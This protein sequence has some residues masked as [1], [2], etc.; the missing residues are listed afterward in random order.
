MKPSS[1]RA[2]DRSRIGAIWLAI[3]LLGACGEGTGPDHSPTLAFIVEPS[4]TEGTA[5]ITPPPQV[6]IQDASSNTD[7]TAET[8]VTV[9]LSGNAGGATLAG[10][11][12]VNAVRGV[13]TF[14]GLR[15]DRPGTVTLTAASGTSTVASGE[16]DI[17]LTI[18]AVAAGANH[19]CA[20]TTVQAA[21]CWGNN[22]DGQLGDGTTTRSATAVLVQSPGATFA[23]LSPA[24]QH[25]CALATDGAAYCWGRGALLGD[26]TSAASS[27]PVRVATPPTGY[28]TLSTNGFHTC[29]IT[30][31]GEAYCWGQAS[32][33]GEMGDGTTESRTSPVR[34]LAA[35]DVRFR[36]LSAGYT[37]TCAITTADEV[38][39]WGWGTGPTPAPVA[40]PVGMTPLQ[41]AAG[42][43]HTCVLMTT[44]AAYCWGDN[45]KGQLGDGTTEPRSSPTPVSVPD[46]VRFTALAAGW[47]HNCGLTADGTLYCWGADAYGQLGDG[48][49]SGARPTPTVVSAPTGLRFGAMTAGSNFTCARTA[50]GLVYCWGAND[51]GKLGNGSEAAWSTLP[52]QIVQ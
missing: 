5:V 36:S 6:A 41:V 23:L 14:T 33:V 1:S 47:E 3:A 34:V 29:A 2:H 49:I 18:A 7:T 52:V 25:T 15:I 32:Y 26:G 22:V 43:A 35:A 24:F 19:A 30:Q 11:T 44:G 21:Y 10:T 45:L 48:A 31:G 13:A 27:K 46:S 12:T 38:Y 28:A 9:R 17:V 39:C 40:M 42:M 20:I 37:H 51:A 50:G 4:R 8:T 16:F